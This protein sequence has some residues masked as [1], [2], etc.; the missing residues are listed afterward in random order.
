MGIG[1]DVHK[2]AASVKHANHI[3][4][5]GEVSDIGPYLDSADI[6]ILPSDRPEPFGLVLLE[7]FAR[8]RCVVASNGGGATDIVT[9]GHN[10]RL[11]QLGS[12]EDL[13][14]CLFSLNRVEAQRMGTN[15]RATY[16]EKY[17]IGAYG[18]KRPCQQLIS[19][20]GT[21]IL[22]CPWTEAACAHLLG[23]TL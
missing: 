21:A 1:V 14:A 3:S 19:F 20:T 22:K 4:L 13:A 2:L 11:F 12:S 15:A 5:V 16:E 17:S 18:E 6:L 8:G 10:G 9:D 7:A 23:M